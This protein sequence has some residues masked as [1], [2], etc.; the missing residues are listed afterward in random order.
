[1]KMRRQMRHISALESVSQL[2]VELQIGGHLDGFELPEWA[3][4]TS[5]EE[6]FNAV[7]Y[8]GDA[9]WLDGV[10]EGYG[11][12]ESADRWLED[13]LIGTPV[14]DKEEAESN[15]GNASG[16]CGDESEE[17]EP[18]LRPSIYEFLDAIPKGLAA[19]F[20]KR[21][22]HED[23]F[24]AAALQNLQAVGLAMGASFGADDRQWPTLQDQ[25]TFLDPESAGDPDLA[26]MSKHFLVDH[27][28]EYVKG[29]SVD[30]TTR[31]RA[32][33]RIMALAA[34]FERAVNATAGTKA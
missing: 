29:M 28:D 6:A 19:R 11:A 7:R 22:E 5:V 12:Q 30:N 20:K 10:Y 21:F 2:L 25:F 17:D 33:R 9:E 32:V 18:D 23:G 4:G 24:D 8:I 34:Q 14:P 31:A 15:A 26:V 1:M 27:S 13:F 16:G 3:K